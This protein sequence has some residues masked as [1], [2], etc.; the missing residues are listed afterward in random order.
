MNEKLD[1]SLKELIATYGRP[2]DDDISQSLVR[3][4][5]EGN[6]GQ[7]HRAMNE[8]IALNDLY[9]ARKIYWLVKHG[10]S[11]ARLATVQ[12]LGALCREQMTLQ[13]LMDFSFDDE[14]QIV[15]RAASQVLQLHGFRVAGHDDG[16]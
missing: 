7:W 5:A 4:M 2:E 12:V 10:N 9:S 16:T 3:A 6:P 11:S 14:S 1:S 13:V 8:L 15:R